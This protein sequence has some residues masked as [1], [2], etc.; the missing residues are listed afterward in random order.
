MYLPLFSCL[1]APVSRLLSHF[2]CITVNC[3]MSL[4]CCPLSPASCILF[5]VPFSYF[6]SLVSYTGIFFH[7]SR[8]LKKSFG[9]KLF[10]KYCS[11]THFFMA[12]ILF[13]K[14]WRDASLALMRWRANFN[15]NN[16]EVAQRFEKWRALLYCSS[17]GTSKITP[18][19][20]FD[21]IFV[22]LN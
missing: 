5:L 4:V 17:T 14:M 7:F 15:R 3:I 20:L 22:P 9:R 2:S 10:E 11:V 21:I 12:Q 13:P 19:P 1:T 18:K 8:L 6:L 16:G